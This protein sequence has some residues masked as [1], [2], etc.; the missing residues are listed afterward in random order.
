MTQI[1]NAYKTYH[2]GKKNAV[3]ALQGLSIQIAKGEMVA[4][5]GKSGSGK[6]T[7][8][9]ALGCIDRFQSGSY[10]L[11]GLDVTKMSDHKLASIRNEKIGYVFQ[12]FAL[13]ETDTALEN[14]MLPFYFNKTVSLGEARERGMQAMKSIGISKLGDKPVNEL[15][16]GQKQRVAIARAIVNQ[17]SVILADEPTGALDSKT[18]QEIMDV[19]H[20][21]HK[22]GK[23]ILIVTHDMGIAEQCERIIEIADG[24]ILT[25]V[26]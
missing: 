6:T 3:K 1:T 9:N 14:V 11:D 21:L 8:L 15:S 17:P 12:N 10:L 20:R 24:R 22:S 25:D 13:V 19:F 18:A 4:I 5:I 23:T 7:L 2:D 26:L 16:G